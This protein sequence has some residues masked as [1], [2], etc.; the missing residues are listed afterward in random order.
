MACEEEDPFPAQ[1]KWTSRA[2]AASPDASRG[3]AQGSW[4]RQGS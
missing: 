3:T 2:S 4:K 1:L